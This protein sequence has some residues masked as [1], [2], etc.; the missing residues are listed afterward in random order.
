MA[1]S[2]TVPTP[3]AAPA[4]P[5]VRYT[6]TDGFPAVLEGLGATLLVTTYQ[7]GKLVVVRTRDGRVSTLLRS[8]DQPMGLAANPRRMVVGTRSQVWTLCNAPDLAP[9]LDPPGQ[10]DA[11]FLPRSC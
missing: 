5:V 6:Y 8:F 11:C 4:E 9:Q 2:E 3:S 7:A 1:Y 10:H